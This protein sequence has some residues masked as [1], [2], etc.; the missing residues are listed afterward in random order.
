[1]VECSLRQTN[2]LERDADTS[3]VQEPDGDLVAVAHAAEHSLALHDAV[4]ERNFACA[5]GTYS[6]FVLVAPHVQAGVSGVNDERS[7]S[8]VPEGE[9]REVT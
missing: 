3:F 2:R 8:L 1:M 9:N 4:C 5:A 7:D 6:E